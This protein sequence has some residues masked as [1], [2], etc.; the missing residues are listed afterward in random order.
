MDT[1]GALK[2]YGS[3]TIVLLVLGSFIFGVFS[4]GLALKQEV[5]T[6]ATLTIF[7]IAVLVLH[8]I[9]LRELKQ[10]IGAKNG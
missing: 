4:V 1:L 9:Q 10:K 5:S 6:L 8:E 7:I 3:I 2:H